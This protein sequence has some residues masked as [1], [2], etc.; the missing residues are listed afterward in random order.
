MT[1]QTKLVV[2]KLPDQ[3]FRMSN[4]TGA[5]LKK[6]YMESMLY[7][8]C[9]GDYFAPYICI[10]LGLRGL[11]KLRKTSLR[12]VQ[13]E[14]FDS[15]LNLNCDYSSYPVIMGLLTGGGANQKILAS[16]RAGFRGNGYELA[17][18]T[19]EPL[20][21]GDSVAIENLSGNIEFQ[22]FI[23]RHLENGKTIV[24]AIQ[25][26]HVLAEGN[27]AVWIRSSLI[28]S[29][30]DDFVFQPIEFKWNRY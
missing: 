20:S 19:F 22:Q 30:P 23:N 28:Q 16:A 12:K 3:G 24:N 5:M 29:L 26:L 10:Q 7:K 13:A 1:E 11:A 14:Y 9:I 25:N 21:Y 6:W 15:D 18:K 27:E 8:N 2:T 17:P 4:L